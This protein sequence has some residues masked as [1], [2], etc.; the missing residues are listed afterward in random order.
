[1]FVFGVVLVLLLCILLYIYSAVS[2]S[3]KVGT[4]SFSNE[5][6]TFP[7]A[8]TGFIYDSVIYANRLHVNSSGGGH[9]WG[10]TAS[11]TAI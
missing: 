6:F 9:R 3:I 1:M 7:I 10:I 4:S 8:T 2:V 11:L 5:G